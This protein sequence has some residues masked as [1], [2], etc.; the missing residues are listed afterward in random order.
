MSRAALLIFKLA[1]A[2]SAVTA[3]A[4]KP[5]LSP[6]LDDPATADHP[7]ANQREVM[8]PEQQCLK[9]PPEAR[10]KAWLDDM[11]P[12]QRRK[13]LEN[14]DRWEK[15]PPQARERIRE[16][17]RQMHQRAKKDAEEAYRE[18]GLSLSAEGKAAYL[19]RYLEERRSIEEKLRREM[20]ARRRDE[21]AKLKLRLHREFAGEPLND[22]SSGPA[23]THVASDEQPDKQ[24][25][26]EQIQPHPPAASPENN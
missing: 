26:A 8:P 20:E 17:F 22:V 19:R 9:P 5:L 15:L 6:A 12:G 16:R 14:M 7:K 1:F 18:T 11:P 23:A 24:H 4:E 10:W 2:L 13:F 21:L 3:V 25:Q